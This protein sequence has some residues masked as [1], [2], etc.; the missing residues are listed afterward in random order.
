MSLCRTATGA[1]RAK[2]PNG[3][4]AW[5]SIPVVV[6][7]AVS[8]GGAPMPPSPRKDSITEGKDTAR[9]R[10]ATSTHPVSPPGPVK[11]SAIEPRRKHADEGTGHRLKGGG[12]AGT[13]AIAG[14]VRR[15]GQG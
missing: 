11:L 1:S 13:P 9:Y 10:G 8:V 2:A 5:T 7:V 14:P 4:L 6:P 12:G 3:S 15:Q